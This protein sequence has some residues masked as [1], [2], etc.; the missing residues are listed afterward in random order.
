MFFFLKKSSLLFEPFEKEKILPGKFGYPIGG[1]DADFKHFYLE[2]HIENPDFKD[3]NF[4]ECKHWMVQSHQ[5]LG[6]FKY[7]FFKLI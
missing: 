5:S 2:L 4:Q 1:P 7:L 6:L 3:P